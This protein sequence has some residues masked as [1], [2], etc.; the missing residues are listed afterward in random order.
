MVRELAIIVFVDSA[1]SEPGCNTIDLSG[2][3]I[4]VLAGGSLRK[5][6]LIVRYCCSEDTLGAMATLTSSFASS[7]TRLARSVISN[8]ISPTVEEGLHEGCELRIT[9]EQP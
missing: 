2:L 9:L 3:N 5:V 8:D 4:D 1:P 7:L 6:S